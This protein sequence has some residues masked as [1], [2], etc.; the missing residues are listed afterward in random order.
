[1]T[2]S[3]DH[4]ILPL[5]KVRWRWEVVHIIFQLPFTGESFNDIAQITQDSDESFFMHKPLTVLGLR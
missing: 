4:V 3:G 2:D 1:M 5:V